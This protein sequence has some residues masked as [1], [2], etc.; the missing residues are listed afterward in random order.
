M[1][2]HASCA[3]RVG[4]VREGNED[5]WYCAEAGP[6]LLLALVADG[7]GGHNAGEVASELAVAEFRHQVESGHLAPGTRRD[8][9]GPM[10]DIVARRAHVAIGD[11]GQRDPAHRGMGTT[12]TAVL[13]GPAGGTLVQVGDSRCYLWRGEAVEQLSTDQTI[14]RELLDSGRIDEQHYATHPD[15]NRLAQCLGLEDVFNPFEPAITPFDWSPGQRLL[16]CTDGL[17]DMVDDATISRLVAIEPLQEAVQ[18]LVQ[19]ALEAG[20]RDNV[21]TVLIANEGALQME[22]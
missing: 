6:D 9:Q 5:A 16:L 21:T 17:T 7:L 22:R 1:K 20:G 2:L 14:A 19:A 3:S 13:V 15:R 12:L 4:R 10:L 11:A 18:A 8:L